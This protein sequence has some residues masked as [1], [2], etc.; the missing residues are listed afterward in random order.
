MILL[1]SLLS[2]HPIGSATKVAASPD[3]VQWSR[4]N[5]PT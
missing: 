3:V 4:A 1:L 2:P 5:I